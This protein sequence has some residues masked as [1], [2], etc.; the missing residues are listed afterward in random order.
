MAVNR[1][2]IDLP[3]ELA[4]QLMRVA[5]SLGIA[6]LNE[7]AI[8]AIADWTARRGADLDDRDPSQKYIVNEALDE[9][10]AK[11]NR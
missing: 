4:A 8:V 2:D 11:K 6:T 3:D 7:A 1:I 9:L 5:E 10:I